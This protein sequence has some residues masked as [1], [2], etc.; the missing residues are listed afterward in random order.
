M[1][2]EK[3]ISKTS[4]LAAK[5]LFAAFKVL[6]EAGGE[7]PGREVIARIEATVS[8]D[9][10]A[11]E[12]FEKTGNT[13]WKSVL[14]FFTIDAIKAGYLRK[15]QGTWILTPEGKKAIGLG[16]RGL[17]EKVR[18]EY[19]KWRQENRSSEENVETGGE[20]DLDKSLATLAT[21]AE[22]E[23]T[24]LNGLKDFI[25]KKNPY[26]FQD[27]VAALMRGMGYHVPLTASPGKDG[28]VDVIAYQDP[29]GAKTPR[30][31]IQVKHRPNTPSS[32]Q[33]VRELMGI[34]SKAGDVG[35]FVSTGGFTTDAKSLIRSSPTHV[36]LINFERFIAL[37]KENYNKLSDDDK[38][39]L[40]LQSIYF[41][42]PQQ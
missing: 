8:L 9:D 18:D 13:R 12:R 21:L 37:W 1:S 31:K 3:K 32:V 27:L 36:E 41:L 24:A 16:E 10:R 23:Q 11:K 14:H 2:N 39:L 34:L 20:E 33:E 17:L 19:K 28:G 26:E 38:N 30:L 6:D 22:T 35:V 5:T 4:E 25:N 40:P 15:A 7:L 29:L 42:S